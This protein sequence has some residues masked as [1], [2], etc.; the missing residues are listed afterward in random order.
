MEETSKIVDGDP[1][2]SP[3]LLSGQDPGVE[4]LIAKGIDGSIQ[5]EGVDAIHDSIG[6]VLQQ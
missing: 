6:A 4:R 1:C 5:K 2:K 3:F